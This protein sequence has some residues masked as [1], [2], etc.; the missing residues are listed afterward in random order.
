MAAS[1]VRIKGGSFEKALSIFL[2]LLNLVILLITIFWLYIFWRSK[3]RRV[4]EKALKVRRPD[5]MMLS[6]VMILPWLIEQSI[7]IT[8]LYFDETDRYSSRGQEK[9]TYLNDNIPVFYT[10]I[11]DKFLHYLFWFAFWSFIQLKV[12]KLNIY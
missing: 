2:L 3:G 5:Y 1:V 10:K 9:W 4:Y 12:F 7:A 6:Y 11:T 8:Y